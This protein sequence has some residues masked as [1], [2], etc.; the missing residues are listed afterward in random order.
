MARMEPVRLTRTFPVLLRMQEAASLIAAARNIKHPA[1]LSV[2]YGAG[3]R[4]NEV[5]SLKVGDVHRERMA[6]RVEQ[7]KDGKYRYAM[8]SPVVLQCLRAWR[9]V[10]HAQ[11]RILPSGWLFPVLD[12][13]EPLSARQLN[14]VVHDAVACW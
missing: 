14:R 2:P 6:L 11:G 7:G 12:P 4:A 9:R 1:A 10:G 5:G 3:L 13:M 8:L